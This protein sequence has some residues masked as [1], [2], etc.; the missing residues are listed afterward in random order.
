MNLR[1]WVRAA[2]G[3]AA[4]GIALIAVA[5]A[6]AGEPQAFMPPSSTEQVPVTSSTGSNVYSTI[7]YQDLGGG[8]FQQAP[9]DLFYNYYAGPGPYGNYVAEMYVAPLPIPAHVGHTY[10]T[11]QPFYPHNYLQPHKMYYSDGERN[12]RVQ[13]MHHGGHIW[14]TPRHISERWQPRMTFPNA[15]PH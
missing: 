7:Q 5:P 1:T 2:C 15:L 3:A 8:Q 6:I 4:I 12:V 10:Y 14:R 11:Y 13:Y 9:Q